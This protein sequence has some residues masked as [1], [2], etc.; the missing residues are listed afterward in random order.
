M[1]DRRFLDGF[2]QIDPAGQN[3]AQADGVPDLEDL[4]EAGLAQVGV[5]GQDAFAHLGERDRD[6]GDG[7]R[8]ALLRLGAGESD[9]PLVAVDPR[10]KNRRPDVPI[11]LG[12]RDFREEM[13]DE[14]DL[15]NPGRLEALGSG[16]SV[17]CGINPLAAGVPGRKMGDQAQRGK[18]GQLVQ[19]LRILDRV[20][21]EMGGEGQADAQQESQ[22]KGD[23]EVA[24]DV[25][26][27]RLVGDEGPVDDLD[28]ARLEA[29][30]HG[31]D[32]GRLLLGGEG[33]DQGSEALD[34]GVQAGIEK[35]VVVL[36]GHFG[37]LG[38]QHVPQPVLVAEGLGILGVGQV[39]GLLDFRLQLAFERVDLDLE[40]DHLRM[41]GRVRGRDLFLVLR[42]RLV[43][44]RPEGLDRRIADVLG[45]GIHPELLELLVLGLGGDPGDLGAGIGAGRRG[46]LGG[47]VGI[48]VRQRQDFL[49]LGIPLQ[50][51]FLGVQVLPELGDGLGEEI[52][53]LLGRFGARLDR[54]IDVLLDQGV[55]DVGRKPRLGGDIAHVDQPGFGDGV[56]RQALEQA[57]GVQ[58]VRLGAGRFP[59]PRLRR[60]AL[61]PEPAERQDILGHVGHRPVLFHFGQEF[62]PGP[63][64]HLP[65]DP[66]GQAAALDDPQLGVE[67]RAQEIVGRVRRGVE[68]FLEI[69]PAGALVLDQ[70]LGGRRV[71]ARLGERQDR[72]QDQAGAER[73]KDDRPPLPDDGPVFAE[74]DVLPIH[75]SSAGHLIIPFR[76]RPEDRPPRTSLTLTPGRAAGNRPGG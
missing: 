22:E 61:R 6:V 60:P 59:G 30:Q 26:R 31:R 76:F 28:V 69:E 38:F 56:D 67:I 5:D 39:D 17:G 16:V 33:R 34:L 1:G 44:I 10:E 12:D 35:G 8:L 18:P 3:I 21:E 73:R 52:R 40:L 51:A 54:I 9:H 13:V 37:P 25:R 43:I 29:A 42:L 11:I 24:L 32:L 4:V 41:A 14:L 63:E 68:I 27:R 58:G 71:P 55:D 74:V 36:P 72:G 57:P 23:D 75:I 70:D 48:L 19:I 15:R 62:R 50:L 49:L 64:I 46:V 66:L 20:V 45:K 2:G 53:R 47:R 65:D 7:R